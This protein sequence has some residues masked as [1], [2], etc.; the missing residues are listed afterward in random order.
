MVKNIELIYSPS[1]V[2]NRFKKTDQTVDWEI[3]EPFELFVE[4]TFKCRDF[5]TDIP[6]N[7]TFRS[8]LRALNPDNVSRSRLDVTV[9]MKHCPVECMEAVT[10]EMLHWMSTFRH[11]DNRSERLSRSFHL[12]AP[13]GSMK[14][15]N[16]S[17]LYQTSI[18]KCLRRAHLGILPHIR[19]MQYRLEGFQLISETVFFNLTGGVWSGLVNLDFCCHYKTSALD[20]RLLQRN[21][22]LVFFLGIASFREFIRPLPR[23]NRF[24]T[25]QIKIDFCQICIPV[26]IAVLRFLPNTLS[27]FHVFLPIDHAFSL[28]SVYSLYHTDYDVNWYST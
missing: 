2:S 20:L 1:Q 5:Q 17:Q 7:E 3:C 10:M 18:V 28:R 11:S 16:L 22:C 21:I 4:V 19:R 12:N 8:V 24:L 27:H 9:A 6:F 14:K 15:L 13:G 26:V 25:F 23:S